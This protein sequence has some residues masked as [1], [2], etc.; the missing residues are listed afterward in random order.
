MGL[1]GPDGYKILLIVNIIAF[2]TS[3]QVRSSLSAWLPVNL[4]DGADGTLCRGFTTMDQSGRSYHRY[5]SLNG[6]LTCS[7][8]SDTRV[9][10]N[11]HGW[12]LCSHALAGSDLS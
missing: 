6:A 10:T 12:Q 2:L 4:Q 9:R 8:G 1:R 3:M 7:T 11:T 5:V